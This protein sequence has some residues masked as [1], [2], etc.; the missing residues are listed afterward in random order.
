[1]PVELINVLLDQFRVRDISIVR[2]KLRDMAL[3]SSPV[4][5]GMKVSRV[6]V[7]LQ[8]PPNSAALTP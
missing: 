8:S 6:R 4:S 5:N 1:V 3:S 7:A 2:P